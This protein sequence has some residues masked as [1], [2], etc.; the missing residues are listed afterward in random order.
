MMSEEDYIKTL[1]TEPPVECGF[2]VGDKVTFTNDNGCVFKNK[3]IIGFAA[4]DSFY[5]R[6]IHLGPGECF[7]FPAKPS[8]LKLE[9]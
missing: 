7:W 1:K 2:K 9:E 6:F 3:I 4:D 5:G 8:S